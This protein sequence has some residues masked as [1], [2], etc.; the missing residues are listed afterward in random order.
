MKRVH[1]F[2]NGR[3]QGVYYRANTEK[4]ALSLGLK[5]WVRNLN[6]GQVEIIAEG[7]DQKIEELVAWCHHGPADA[8][9]T[10]LDVSYQEPKNEFDKFAIAPTI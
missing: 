7:D 6:R 4:K 1:I 5:G 3:V 9:V 8:H 2:A 10:N